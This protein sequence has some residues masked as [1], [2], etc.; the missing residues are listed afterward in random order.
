VHAMKAYKGEEVHLHTLTSALD[1]GES[2]D[3][4]PGHFNPW[5]ESSVPIN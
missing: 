2:L 3:L 1:G 5:R 4:R